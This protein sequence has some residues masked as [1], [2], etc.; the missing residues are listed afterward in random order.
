MTVNVSIV[1]KMVSMVT[2][3]NAIVPRCVIVVLILSS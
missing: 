1:F 2:T 3:L